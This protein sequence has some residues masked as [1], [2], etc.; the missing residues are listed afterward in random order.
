[1]TKINKPTDWEI[2]KK[3]KV[4]ELT[5]ERKNEISETLFWNKEA[6]LKDLKEHH[7]KIEET[8]GMNWYT[9]KNVHIDLPAVGNFEWFKFDYFASDGSVVNKEFESNSEYKKLSYS[10]EEIAELLAALNKY[11]RA[12]WVIIDDGIDFKKDLKRWKKDEYKIILTWR[13]LKEITWLDGIFWT[14]NKKLFQSRVQR[15]LFG[16]GCDFIGIGDS[17]YNAAELLLKLPN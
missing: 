14:A 11:M 2:E 15:D 5:G 12:L 10:L 6:I 1:M 3:S 9:W 13:C 16:Y 4:Q 8:A 7:V 17:W